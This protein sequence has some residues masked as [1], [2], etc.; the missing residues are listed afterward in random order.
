MKKLISAFLALALAFSFAT[1]ISVSEAVPDIAI[2]SYAAESKP[3]EKQLLPYHYSKL[4]DSGKDIY[5]KLR[6]AAIDHEPK[7]KVNKK[8]SSELFTELSNIIFYEDPLAFN[9]KGVNASIGSNSTEFILSYNFK[10]DSY[11]K[12]L[13][14]MDAT[15]EKII[16]KFD[17]DTSVYSKILYIHDYLTDHTVYDE[18][19]NSA[20]SAYGAM[21]SGKA[22]CEGYARAFGYIC[23][24][25]GIKTVN[26][27]GKGN[28]GDGHV[29][30]HMWNRVYIKKQW[31]DI[32]LTWDDPTSNLVE[33]QSYKYFLP[34]SAVFEQSHKAD[35]DVLDYPE[36]TKDTSLNYYTRKKLVA[37][38][39]KSAQSLLISQISKAAAK[40]KTT[41]TIKLANKEAYQSFKSYIENN[42]CEK[43]YS[44]LSSANKKSKATIVTDRF[45]AYY[46]DDVALTATIGFLVKGTTL[47]DYYTD[48]DSLSQEY[49]DFFK[50]A[51]IT[52]S[53]KQNKKSA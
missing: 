25:A 45:Y 21:I 1:G 19:L 7:L 49:I 51:G 13:K 14:R 8:I 28:N 30:N 44:I 38:D 46:F 3:I 41:A 6:K 10:K 37:K 20:H 52:K 33:N 36:A 22:V 23:A 18:S 40:K 47:S 15:A 32:D 29:V 42:N 4:S 48:V 34:G 26:V 11:D 17:E 5:I 50:Q 31:Y 16:S 12:M 43:I 27:T 39:N 24:K 2:S 53:K 9:V 35:T